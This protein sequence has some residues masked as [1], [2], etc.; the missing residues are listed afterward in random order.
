[1][2]R[3]VARSAAQTPS[4]F[5]NGS[6]RSS[7]S[8]STLRRKATSGSTKSNTTATACTRLDRGAVKLLTRTGLDWTHKYPAI[9]NAAA[10]PLYQ[11]PGPE[12]LAVEIGLAR[13][14]CRHGFGDR[15]ILMGPFEPGAC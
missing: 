6:G 7:P 8:W 14:K 4:R 13:F 11:R 1:M 10:E 5:R 2:A 9:A 3:S 12:I 15:R